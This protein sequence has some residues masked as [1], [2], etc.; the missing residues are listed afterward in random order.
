MTSTRRHFQGKGKYFYG[1]GSITIA[2]L[3]A[4]AEADY[5]ITDANAA[6]GD[7][8]SVSLANADMETGVAILGAWVSAAG[9]ISIRIGNVHTS[10]LTGGAATVYYTIS[11]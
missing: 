8:I 11:N 9:T 7:V 10:G 3:A 5:T 4:A 6:V 1:S 2:A